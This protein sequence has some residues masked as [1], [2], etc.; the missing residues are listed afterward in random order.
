MTT[1][2]NLLI[3][4]YL[5]VLDNL[6]KVF[7]CSVITDFTSTMSKAFDCLVIISDCFTDFVFLFLIND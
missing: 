3:P 6:C 7:G 5:I 2:T 1:R 4:S